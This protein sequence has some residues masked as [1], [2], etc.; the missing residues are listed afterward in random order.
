MLRIARHI[1]NVPAD[2]VQLSALLVHNMGHIAEQ[3]VQLPNALLDIT[4]FRF[5][6]NDQRLLE[7]HFVLRGEA[8]LILFL[9]LRLLL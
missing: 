3:L 2:R 5:P 9:D 1:L 8:Q 7:I 4:Y 6:L